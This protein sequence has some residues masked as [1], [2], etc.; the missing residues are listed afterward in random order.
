M[1]SIS[2]TPIKTIRL[3]KHV[4]MNKLS[5]DLDIQSRLKLAEISKYQKFVKNKNLFE[6][7][8]KI[9]VKNNTLDR[10]IL[11]NKQLKEKYGDLLLNDEE[12]IIPDKIEISINNNLPQN[13][14]RKTTETDLFSNKIKLQQLKKNHKMENVEKSKFY[15]CKNHFSLNTDNNNKKNLISNTLY[16]ENENNGK[17]SLNIDKFQPKTFY[18]NKSKNDEYNKSLISKSK[19]FSFLNFNRI[20]KNSINYDDINKNLT[21]TL[22]TRTNARKT[23]NLKALIHGNYNKKIKKICVNE[24]FKLDKISKDI[25]NTL[26]VAKKMI[27]DNEFSSKKK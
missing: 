24:Y 22:N 20:K 11:Y 18:L 4:M 26:T 1:R 23:Q 10:D 5:K 27:L 9:S 19:D 25:N 6:L 16:S 2:E 17:L 21:Q 8:Y 14:F 15:S 7:I 13:P 3:P 12:S